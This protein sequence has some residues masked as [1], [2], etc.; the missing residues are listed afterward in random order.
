MRAL[1]CRT[2]KNDTTRQRERD[3]NDGC[4]REHRNVNQLL[5][6]PFS[7]AVTSSVKGIFFPR[8]THQHIIVTNNQAG[9]LLSKRNE[10]SEKKTKL[11]RNNFVFSF[12][13]FLFLLSFA[14]CSFAFIYSIFRKKGR[15]QCVRLTNTA[16]KSTC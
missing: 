12:P 14:A 7:T 13:F 16:L 8:G 2:Q 10:K 3:A 9:K 5:F 15:I 1:P 6:W 4:E 11:F